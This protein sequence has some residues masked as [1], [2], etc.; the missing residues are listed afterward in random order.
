MLCIAYPSSPVRTALAELTRRAR[1]GPAVPEARQHAGVLHPDHAYCHADL[2]GFGL[3]QREITAS[4]RWGAIVRA[5]Q[6]V[7]LAPASAPGVHVAARVGGLV[8]CVS[9]LA[10]LGVFVRD[11]TAT[12]VQVSVHAT[13]LRLEPDVR[14]HWAPLRVPVPVGGVSVDLLDALI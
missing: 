4:V 1:G 2:K 7:Y 5:R 10:A 8:G 11:A 3:S 9:A 12:H 6:G 13:R 14:V